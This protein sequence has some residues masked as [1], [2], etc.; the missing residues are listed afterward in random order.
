MEEGG[1]GQSRDCGRNMREGKTRGE[2]E[3]EDEPCCPH[4]Q[5]DRQTFCFQFQL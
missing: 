4:R 3:E 2:W 5:T 1:A